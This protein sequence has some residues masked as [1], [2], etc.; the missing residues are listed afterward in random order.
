MLLKKTSPLLNL[1]GA[2]VDVGEGGGGPRDLEMEERHWEGGG[3]GGG[4]G[5]D[6]S[7]SLNRTVDSGQYFLID[8]TYGH[9][10]Q[11]RRH[12]G[13]IDQTFSF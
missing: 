7:D 2:I 10:G 5:C 4:V 3:K 11:L 13:H 9:H 6:I 8:L 12:G 1:H